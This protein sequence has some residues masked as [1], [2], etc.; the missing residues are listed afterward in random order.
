MHVLPQSRFPPT[1]IVPRRTA[2]T[3]SPPHLLPGY[4][5][6]GVH[7]RLEALPH[8]GPPWLS[9]SRAEVSPRRL[10]TH[11]VPWLTRHCTPE[12][13]RRNPSFRIPLSR[14]CVF[15]R[16]MR[17]FPGDAAPPSPTAGAGGHLEFPQSALSPD[18][19]GWQILV[20]GPAIA[21]GD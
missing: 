16:R 19:P 3:G 5:L 8:C 17:E 18:S 1:S 12:Q 7:A 11:A 2:G 20:G 15:A 6:S 21:S 9:P 14:P 4:L 10:P 13:R